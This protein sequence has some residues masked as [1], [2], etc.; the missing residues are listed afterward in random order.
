MAEYREMAESNRSNLSRVAEMLERIHTY[1]IV[2]NVRAILTKSVQI[3]KHFIKHQ[4]EFFI[5]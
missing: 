2:E 1:H 3:L 5:A 4:E